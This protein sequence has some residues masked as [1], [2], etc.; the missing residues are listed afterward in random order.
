MARNKTQTAQERTREYRA[1]EFLAWHVTQKGDKRF[2]FY[3]ASHAQR[4]ADYL[5]SRQPDAQQAAA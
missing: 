3:V 5:K 4:A 2:I 1:P